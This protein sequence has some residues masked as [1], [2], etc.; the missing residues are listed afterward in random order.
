[1]EL[2]DIY[3]EF[4]AAFRGGFSFADTRF[5]VSLCKGTPKYNCPKSAT[6]RIDEKTFMWYNKKKRRNRRILAV[7]LLMNGIKNHCKKVYLITVI[8][9]FCRQAK[10]CIHAIYLHHRQHF[11][12]CAFR[13][14]QPHCL[15][16]RLHSHSACSVILRRTLLSPLP[17]F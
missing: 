7:F 2:H 11:L 17:H 15:H 13:C 1:M 6:Q 8:L 3:P 10:P 14:S 12:P 4:S 5:T 16:I 9:I